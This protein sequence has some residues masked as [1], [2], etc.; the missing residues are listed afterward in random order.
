MLL[1]NKIWRQS[2]KFRL[3]TDH[4]QVVLESFDPHLQIW[5]T[6]GQMQCEYPTV[7]I[8]AAWLQTYPQL[9]WGHDTHF[10]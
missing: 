5:K 1:K 3:Q 6:L 2:L 7:S 8:L 9:T 10:E 4:H